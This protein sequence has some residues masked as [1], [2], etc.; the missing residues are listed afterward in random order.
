MSKLNL[1]IVGIMFSVLCLSALLDDPRNPPM[2]R[3]RAPGERT[4]SAT[5]CHRGGTFVGTVSL[6][7]LPD[8]VVSG[9][10]YNLNIKQTSNALLGGFEATS[11]DGSNMKAGNFSISNSTTNVASQSGRQYV[12]Q[13]RAVLL[14][15]GSV[16]WD[17]D[18]T[19]PD[20][21]TSGDSITFYFITNATNND[22]RETGDNTFL[23]SRKVVLKINTSVSNLPEDQLYELQIGK[24]E[25]FFTPL[26][27]YVSV[28]VFN[29][30]G[31]EL[32][33]FSAANSLDPLSLMLQSGVHILN[34]EYKSGQK[35]SKKIVIN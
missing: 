12:R 15:Q 17:F 6:T 34:I 21:L 27:P 30:N 31:R 26:K 13:S 33:N 14:S 8:T 16:S 4:C 20:A 24:G 1:L 7:G 5:D 10:K 22:D 35:V 29:L 28:R 11:L 25:L 32:H 23:S 2:G 3:T 18:W 9:T 19:A